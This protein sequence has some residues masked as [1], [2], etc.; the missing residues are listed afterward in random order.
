LVV[1]WE[2]GD[3]GLVGVEVVVEVVT[4][5]ARVAGSVGGDA[6]AGGGLDVGL[7]CRRRRVCYRQG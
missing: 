1:R 3:G 6:K 5:G 2:R 7:L 4:R